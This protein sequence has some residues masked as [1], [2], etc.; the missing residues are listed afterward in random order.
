[1]S[2]TSELLENQLPIHLAPNDGNSD[3]APLFDP[4]V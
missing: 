1:M 2:A 4:I 3:I